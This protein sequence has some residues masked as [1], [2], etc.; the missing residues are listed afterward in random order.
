MLTLLRLQLNGKVG[1]ITFNQCL[2]GYHF[3]YYSLLIIPGMPFQKWHPLVGPKNPSNSRLKKATFI[4]L[5]LFLL[6][7]LP[8]LDQITSNQL[9]ILPFSDFTTRA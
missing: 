7:T 4:G 3:S 8:I 5:W 1:G 2:F 6:I 9:L